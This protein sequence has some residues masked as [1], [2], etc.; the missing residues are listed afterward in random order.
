MAEGQDFQL[1]GRATSE[2]GG[3]S[4]EERRKEGAE[5]EPKEERQTPTY[6]L[7]RNLREPQLNFYRAK[8]SLEDHRSR[9]ETHFR[10]HPPA[11]VKEAAA[12]IE[13][14]TGVRRRLSHVR[15]FLQRL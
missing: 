14:R 9:L 13:N 7:H 11:S 8:S 6:Q 2:R 5:R 3:K 1:Q 15:Q 4:R 12:V 10:D